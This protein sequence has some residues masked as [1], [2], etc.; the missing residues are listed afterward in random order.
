MTDTLPADTR[1]PHGPVIAG[2]GVGKEDVNPFHLTPSPGLVGWMGDHDITLGFTTYGVGKV[3][4]LGPGR[5]GRLA[6]SERSFGR[7]M[8]LRAT[9]TGL[10]L[11]TQHQIWHFENG[12][13][14]GHVF[15]GWDRLYMPR[16]CH[17]TG[18]V[19][20]HDIHLGSDGTP[21]AAVTLYNCLAELDDRGSFSPIWR[22]A[23]IDGI[24]N[25]D[26]CHLNGFCMENGVPAYASVIGASNVAGG[27]REMRGHGGL[28]IDVRT[29]AVV[30]DGLSMPH[31]PRLYRNE[32]YV[33]EAGSGWFG[34][35]DR[36]SGR[37]ERLTWCPGFLRGLSFHGD[38]AVVALSKPRNE[39][40]AGLP[41]DGE[42]AQRNQE[43]ECGVYVIRLS[44]YTVRHKLTITGSVEEIYDTT[45]LSG[46]R[47]P[48][49]IGV[50]REEIT[51][52]VAVGP[53][54]STRAAAPELAAG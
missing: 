41:L 53:D 28:V 35:I 29:D 24:V 26:R 23:F 27:W 15:D 54:R 18:G 14:P 43:P 1:P 17:V 16:S 11:S 48:L 32:L 12:L 7:A 40:F 33:L 46:A 19:D 49:L 5:G 10:Y 42:L 39:V 31:T 38:Y 2:D 3:V 50:E 25:E 34:R 44:D 8:A 47:Q 37:F 9:E 22:P 36:Q 51:K 6:V 20:V 13:E 21:I 52:Y 30:T 4:L 45:V